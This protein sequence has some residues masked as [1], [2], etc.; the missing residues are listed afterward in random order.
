M[1]DQGPFHSIR[2]V[3]KPNP[4]S[5]K[6]RGFPGF[7]SIPLGNGFLH[8]IRPHLTAHP[9][10]RAI[11]LTKKTGSGSDFDDELAVCPV[12]VLVALLAY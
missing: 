9:P 7:S 11:N 5:A 2:S 4:E 3:Q 10:V 6:F 12:R 8:D 1:A